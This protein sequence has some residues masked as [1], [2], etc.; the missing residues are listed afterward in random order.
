MKMP[1]HL[2]MHAMHNQIID[3]RPDITRIGAVSDPEA[4]L[5]PAPFA[6]CNS[7]PFGNKF[8]LE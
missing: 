8:V 1:P 2:D 7:V 3:P 4:P 6:F 5:S